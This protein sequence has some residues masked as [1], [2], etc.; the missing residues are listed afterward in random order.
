MR[1]NFDKN[2][3]VNKLR[4]TFELSFRSFIIYGDGSMKRH[5]K[6]V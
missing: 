5:K 6:R 3:N 1:Y 4:V 2:M